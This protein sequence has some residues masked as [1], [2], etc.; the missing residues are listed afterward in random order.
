MKTDNALFRRNKLLVTIIWGMLVLGIG[1]DALTAPSVSSIIVLA[2]VGLAACGA[3]TVL[4]YKRWLEEYVMYIISAI[5]TML[6]VLL[7][8]TGPVITT[9]F[10]IYVNLAIMTLYG[11]FRAIAFSSLLGAGLTVYL[12]LSPYKEEMFGDNSPLTIVL[13]LAMIAAPLLASAKFSERLQKAATEG[14]E[15]A[16]G[17]KNKAQAIVDKVASS[18]HMLNSFSANLK[19][20]V[21]STGEISREVTAAFTEI[22]ASSQNQAADIAEVSHSSRSIDAAATDLAE[23][24]TEMRRL[25]VES[26]RLTETGSEEARRLGEQMSQLG[27]AIDASVQIMRQLKEQS[28]RV[29][30]IVAT[31][32]HIS[33]Q[34]NLLALNAAIEAARAGEHGK[35][36]AVVSNEVRKL[37]ETSQ[38]STEQIE[39]ILD[40][41]RLKT[42]EAS[43]QVI[44][45]QTTVIA[46][47]EAASRVGSALS[48]LTEDSGRI[49]RQAEELNRSADALRDQY[50]II[51]DRIINIAAVTEENMASIEQMSSGMQTQD[52]R[53]AEIVDSFLQ[54]DKL[55]SDLN[56]MVEGA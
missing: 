32:K 17:E 3:A 47:R 20:N 4:T 51:A 18:L 56:K 7:I 54:L 40:A 42:D 41:I 28:Q 30:E 53:I 26:V 39:R 52:G 11:S 14:R 35:G 1:V 10:L 15:Q 27:T 19:Q 43:A 48:S 49:E 24:A 21:T 9:Y 44:S 16:L 13:Y 45:G 5:I 34:T 33:T 31:I 29:G 36:F 22:T 23:R 6:T 38:Q 55:A 8:L 50:A 12:F 37:A 2:V 46:S 25:S